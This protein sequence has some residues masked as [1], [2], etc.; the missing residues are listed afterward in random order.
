MHA[1]HDCFI[2]Y[3][4]DNITLVIMMDMSKYKFTK[5]LL[6]ISYIFNLFIYYIKYINILVV[7]YIEIVIHVAII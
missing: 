2:L 5:L 4:Y 7:I 6:F 3:T 1:M